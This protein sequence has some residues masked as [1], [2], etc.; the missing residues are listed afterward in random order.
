VRCRLSILSGLLSVALSSP[1]V[2]VIYQVNSSGDGP[3]DNTGDGVCQTAT[4]GECTLRAAVQQA[5]V[6]GGTVKVPAI[7][8]TLTDTLYVQ[9]DMSIVG[10]G[11]RAT[12]V[13]GNGLYGILF[14]QPAVAFTSLTVSV[15][16]LTLRDGH[17]TVYSGAIYVYHSTLTVERCLFTNNYAPDAGALLADSQTDMRIRDS[18][19]TD[20]HAPGGAAGAVYIYGATLTMTGTAV[21]GNS[22]AYGGGIILSGSSATLTNCT[23][24]GNIA[25]QDGGGIA[26]YRTANSGASLALYS[27]TVIG[28]KATS[29]FGG[30]IFLDDLNY[31][32]AA[33][34]NTIIAGNTRTSKGQI[35]SS[36]CSPGITSLGNSIV[37]GICNVT[38]SYSTANPLVGPL[39]DNGGPSFTYALVTGSPARDAGTVGGCPLTDQRGVHRQ[40]GVACDIG[41][42]EHSPC[43]DANG[44]GA[45]SLT[46]VFFLI[47]YLFAGGPA[48]PG[49]ANVNGDGVLSISDAFFLINFMFAGGSTPSCP[50]T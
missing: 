47:N 34:Q 18:V 12:V 9:H 37:A 44:D 7:T 50:G 17:A 21:H 43:G 28:N 20:N 25:D 24:G 31:S 13:S 3:D 22:A 8:I 46:D 2:A 15:S 33:I 5:N 36:D 1:A 11:M 26:L 41:A 23:V 27:T 4:P 6:T 42:Y 10:A 40:T 29:G 32:N 35:V 39:Q 48:P 14:V 19:F 38:G 49:L 30:G 16:D 45:L